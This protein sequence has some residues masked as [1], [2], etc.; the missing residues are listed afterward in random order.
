M[1]GDIL[2]GM[3]SLAI[4]IVNYKTK[5]YL[6]PLLTSIFKD[7]ESSKIKVEVNILDNNSGDNL[8]D[9]EQKWSNHN[10]K[11]YYS[12][13]NGGYG[14]GHNILASKTNADYLLLLNPD[15]R[16]IEKDTVSRLLKT[17]EK[18]KA[19]VVGPRLLTKKYRDQPHNNELV[20]QP[21]D[22]SISEE[23]FSSYEVHDSI[24]KATYVSGAVFLINRE[25]FVDIG[26]FDERFFLYHEEVDL[27]DR[28][29]SK[30][31]VVIYDP[32]IQ[33]YHYR[34]AVASKK[35]IYY[36]KSTIYYLLKKSIAKSKIGRG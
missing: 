30:G 13:K 3:H 34:H 36:V 18:T 6:I 9:V 24:V 32:S 17:L 4:Q 16:F 22:H 2:E 21:W 25:K 8:K 15:T 26:G 10:L 1:P 31:A 12:D 27:C 11:V 33:V 19:T 14:A 23:F 35:S 5:G 29:R 20:Q 28:L 7:I